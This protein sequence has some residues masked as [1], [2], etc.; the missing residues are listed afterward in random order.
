V[1]IVVI[2]V[3]K[4]RDE[5]LRAAVDDY[6]SRLRKYVPTEER[7]LKTDKD[8]ATAV[9][10]G[11]VTVALEVHGEPVTSPEL[12]KR[13]AEWGRR[14]KGVIAF[15]IGGAE[16]IPKAVSAN[17]DV[18]LSLSRLTLPHRLARVLLAEQLYRAMTIL[19]GEPYARE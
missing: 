6:L 7:E 17:A 16:G 10:A 14:G 8:L 3:G 2:A 5:G 12:A 11:A 1:K 19:R 9:P 4:M 15:L 18:R 13:V